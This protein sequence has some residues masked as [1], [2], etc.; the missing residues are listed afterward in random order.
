M[1][2]LC[3]LIP[4]AKNARKHPEAQLKQIVA[5]MQEFGWTIPVLRD[6][7]GGIIAGHARCIAARRLGWKEAPTMTAVG[8]TE[9][10]KRAYVIAD[11]K[12]SLGSEWDEDMLVM[13]LG[14]LSTDGFDLALTG[15]GED[16]LRGLLHEGQAPAD[17]ETE[18]AQHKGNL[19]ERFGIPPFSVLNAREGW[20]QARKQAWLALGIKSEI[21]RG[22][23]LLHMSEQMIAA[24]NGGDPYGT[25]ERKHSAAPG[26]DGGGAGASGFTREVS[27]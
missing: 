14:D 25:R 26:G 11:N 15:F 23:N 22:E 2:A 3:S 8:W 1:V 7:A 6:E 4:Y 19:A 24:Q 13:E 21:G 10:Q 17:S 5:S 20:W 9:A 12:L 18:A 27:A 16:E